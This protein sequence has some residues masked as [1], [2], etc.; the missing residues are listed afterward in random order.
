MKKNSILISVILV[1]CLVFSG[2]NSKK[3][4]F[5]IPKSGGIPLEPIKYTV[6]INKKESKNKVYIYNVANNTNQILKETEK[7]FENL[8]LEKD[9]NNQYFG[10][11]DNGFDVTFFTNDNTWIAVNTNINKESTAE[12]ITLSNSDCI[13]IAKNF[14]DKHK[15]RPKNFDFASVGTTST[16]GGFNTPEKIIEKSVYFYPSIDGKQVY[17]NSRII[18]DINANGDIIKIHGYNRNINTN[19]KKEVEIINAD[20]AVDMTVKNHSDVSA[21]ISGKEKKITV[22]EAELLYYSDI[23]MNTVQP[24]WSITGIAENNDNTTSEYEALIP[25][26]YN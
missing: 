13:D 2:C 19:E 18:V 14:L 22:K 9:G 3:A 8:K 23:E 20:K 12:E 25:A 16:G 15:I 6:Q 21:N 10:H 4:A 17:G 5:S 11:A 24:I 26:V 7:M 1:I